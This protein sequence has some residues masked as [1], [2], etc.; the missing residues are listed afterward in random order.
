MPKGRAG[1]CA[2]TCAAPRFSPVSQISVALNVEVE[3]RSRKKAEEGGNEAAGS[4]RD[5]DTYEDDC[6]GGGN[7]GG[8]GGAEED[9]GALAN[10]LAVGN[11]RDSEVG[12]VSLPE[13]AQPPAWSQASQ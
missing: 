8:G 7:E 11:A 13:Y 5:E 2:C 10:C 1:E 9:D 3:S 4:D 6:V 12:G